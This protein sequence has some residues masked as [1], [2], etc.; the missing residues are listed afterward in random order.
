M[1]RLKAKGVEVV[2]YEPVLEEDC[3]HN[4]RVVRDLDE[5]LRISDVIVANRFSPELED[6][7]EKVYTRDIFL[8][9]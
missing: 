1:K 6:V 3:F 9:D 7:K 4:S 5:F 2:V 8:R